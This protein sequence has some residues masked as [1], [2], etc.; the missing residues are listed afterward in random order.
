[1]KGGID[2]SLIPGRCHTAV[3]MGNKIIYFGGSANNSSDV[4]ILDIPAL[5]DLERLQ[6]EGEHNNRQ[7]LSS[8]EVVRS[9]RNSQSSS[10]SEAT[11]APKQIVPCNRCSATSVIIGRYMLMF[12]GW[13]N[14]R[15]E[16]G[17]LWALDLAPGL[18]ACPRSS[19]LQ[20]EDANDLTRSV[21]TVEFDEDEYL[22]KAGRKRTRID[23]SIYESEEALNQ[24]L[25]IMMAN[26]SGLTSNTCSCVLIPFPCS[27]LGC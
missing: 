26:V 18:Q 5:E 23:A 21:L 4:F 8:P 12:G 13:S 22:E 17:D 11:A 19:A 25:T 20:L 2:E 3:T 15:R 10:T 16:L 1:M 27:K 9:N 24:I 6:E 7:Y 14:A